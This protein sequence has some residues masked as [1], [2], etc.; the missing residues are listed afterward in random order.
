MRNAR[1]TVFM[2]FY[3]IVTIFRPSTRKQKAGVFQNLH[4]GQY[5]LETVFE[6][7]G[8]LVPSKPVFLWTEGQNGETYVHCTFQLMR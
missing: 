1:G 5:T 4:S 2:M 6:T 3:I 7:C 8:L